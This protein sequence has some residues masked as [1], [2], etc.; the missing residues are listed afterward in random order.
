[1]LASAATLKTAHSIKTK[2]G[3]LTARH[4]PTGPHG[5]S[6]A[7]L[8]PLSLAAAR[9]TIGDTTNSLGSSAGLAQMAVFAR[10][11]LALGSCSHASPAIAGANLMPAIQGRDV[12][13]YPQENY[14]GVSNESVATPDRRP[15]SGT[16]HLVVPDLPFGT[17]DFT[18]DPPV[19]VACSAKMCLGGKNFS[20]NPGYGNYLCA[21]CLPG[22]FN[23][24]STCNVKC[25]D[26]E[27]LRPF[28]T[29]TVLLICVVVVVW[30]GINKLTAGE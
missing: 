21:Q 4:V 9:K 8:H 12:L 23:F 18:N 26:I 11:L 17:E 20:C 24:M 1:M 14:W 3:R 29:V 25:S 7:V 28:G 27:V 30:I 13:P 2:K 5:I 16:K 6:T 22:Q 15:K 19:F 10:Y